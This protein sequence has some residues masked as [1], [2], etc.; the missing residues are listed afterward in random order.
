MPQGIDSTSLALFL[1]IRINNLLVFIFFVFL[2]FD[3]TDYQRVFF[4]HFRDLIFHVL[5]LIWEFI[6]IAIYVIIAVHWGL[7]GTV[8]VAG[9]FRA[10]YYQFFVG[11]PHFGFFGI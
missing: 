8:C 11:F 2:I 10:E 5:S 7:K 1:Q 4:F 3:P 9:V 6:V